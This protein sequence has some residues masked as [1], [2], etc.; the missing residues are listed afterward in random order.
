MKVHELIKLLQEQDQ[1]ATILV[2][3]EN[4]VETKFSVFGFPVEQTV[5]LS[6]RVFDEAA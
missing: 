4:D 6:T 5:Y 3:T 2:E 1:E